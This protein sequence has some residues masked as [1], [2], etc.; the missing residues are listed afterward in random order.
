LKLVPFEEFVGPDE[1]MS[2]IAIR[3]D[4]PERLGYVSKK[5]NIR[6]CM[7]FRDDGITRDDVQNILDSSGLGMPTY[8]SWRSRSGCYFCFFQSQ[9]EWAGLK[10][11]HEDLFARAKTYERPDERTGQVYTWNQAGLL[12]EVVAKAQAKPDIASTCGPSKKL[13]D[14]FSLNEVIDPD[15]GCLICMK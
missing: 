2:Y 13:I 5:A 9:K 1:A 10:E 14:K 3:A 15:D 4:E 7:P 12:D 8:Y 11:K 6:T